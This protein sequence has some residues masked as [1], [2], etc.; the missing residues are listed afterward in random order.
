MTDEVPS[1]ETLLNAVEAVRVE[2]AAN[3]EVLGK[4]LTSLR[5]LVIQYYT[6]VQTRADDHARR[7]SRIEGAL[8][9]PPLPPEDP[10]RA[11]AG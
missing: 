7:L 4:A 10:P 5:T 6:A 3:H 1:L 9:L 2:V 8:S 11:L